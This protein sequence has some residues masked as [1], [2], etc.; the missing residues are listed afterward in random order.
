MAVRRFYTPS[1]APA[2]R[3]VI[4][5]TARRSPAARGRR[6]PH[7]PH[8]CPHMQNRRP[9]RAAVCGKSHEHRQCER[10]AKHAHN[11][12]R[13]ER[14]EIDQPRHRI[15]TAA[16]SSAAM[17]PLPASPCAIPKRASAARQR[18]RASAHGSDRRHDCASENAERQPCGRA[19]ACASVR[20]RSARSPS[21][22]AGS[23][24]RPRGAPPRP[25]SVRQ[26]H[27]RTMISSAT[28][29]TVTVCPRP[30]MSPAGRAPQPG[31]R[32]RGQ[33]RDGRKVVW[34]KGMPESQQATDGQNRYN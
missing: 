3:N 2:A 33:C 1:A 21:C 32:S 23:V 30:Q 27:A 4:M 25:E 14:R 31:G 10:Y 18:P 29:P 5:A 6:P 22:R 7:A 9:P 26:T 15:G 16:T 8:R 34:L 20:A 17:A 24:N 11:R 28:A 19:R 13:A 12:P